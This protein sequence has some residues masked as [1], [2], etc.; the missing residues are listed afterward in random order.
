M[1]VDKHILDNKC[2]THMNFLR[3]FY[4]VTVD[5]ASFWWCSRER[6][7]CIAEVKWFSR[8]HLTN[9]NTALIA[10]FM[11]STWGRQ[12]PGGPHDGPMNF[13]IWE[14]S[15]EDAWLLAE[16]SEIVLYC[17]AVSSVALTHSGPTTHTCVREQSPFV[18]MMVW[19]RIGTKPLLRWCYPFFNWTL[20]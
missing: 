12:D 13:A 15:L 5:D 19:R 8:I 2:Y 14:G 11:G 1:N 4:C 3:S 9:V 18:H 17:K 16:R 20:E 10:R 6:V 7:V